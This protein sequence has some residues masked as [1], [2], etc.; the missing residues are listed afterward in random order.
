M[1]LAN[2][3]AAV[4]AHADLID[5]SLRGMGRGAGNTQLETLVLLL[6]R[7]GI[8]QDVDVTRLLTAAEDVI[9]PLM[10][11]QKGLPSLDQLT[12]A[13]NIDLFPMNVYAAISKALG[14]SLPALITFFGCLT[15]LVEIDLPTIKDAIRHFKGDIDNVLKIVG[16]KP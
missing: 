15:D 4:H 7:L 11:P 3:L 8:A 13:S 12:A 6:N 10:P 2:T 5:A 1:A 9:E 16:I 14:V